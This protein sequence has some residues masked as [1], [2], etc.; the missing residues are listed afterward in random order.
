[1]LREAKGKAL[2]VIHDAIVVPVDAEAEKEQLGLLRAEL[3]RSV[4]FATHA[5]NKMAAAELRDIAISM[6]IDPDSF[7]DTDGDEADD[8]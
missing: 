7:D 2:A 5:L 8:D 3:I 4:E 6:G 1:M